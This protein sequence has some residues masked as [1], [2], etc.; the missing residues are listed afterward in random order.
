MS[1]FLEEAGG[2]EKSSDCSSPHKKESFKLPYEFGKSKI[3]PNVDVEFK[4]EREDD[5]KEEE[6]ITF[7]QEEFNVRGISKR[8]GIF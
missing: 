4:I 8:K 5:K 1:N 6:S 7:K 2:L 3:R